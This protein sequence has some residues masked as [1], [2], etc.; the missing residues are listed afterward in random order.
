MGARLL[1]G[2]PVNSLYVYDSKYKINAYGALL[3]AYVRLVGR[4][5]GERLA[6]ADSGSERRGVRQRREPRG[7]GEGGCRRRGRPSGEGG[8]DTL[9]VAQL[10]ETSRADID[11]GTIGR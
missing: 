6:A 5:D 9:Q 7:M 4:A 10:K 3:D 8:D 2:G 1:P 11:R